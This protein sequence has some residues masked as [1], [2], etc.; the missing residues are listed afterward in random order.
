MV[1]DQRDRVVHARERARV[2]ALVGVQ[3]RAR[4]R[5]VAEP[6]PHEHLRERAR[7]AERRPQRSTAAG[8]HGA[9]ARRGRR[10]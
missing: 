5:R 9:I 4:R 1:Q 2:V 6:A 8:S 7:A 10:T 3:E